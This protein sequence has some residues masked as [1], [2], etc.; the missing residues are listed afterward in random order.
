MSGSTPTNSY[1]GSLGVLPELLYHVSAPTK[2]VQEGIGSTPMLTKMFLGPL[3]WEHSHK[4]GI[5]I[6]AVLPYNQKSYIGSEL[7]MLYNLDI[8]LPLGTLGVLPTVLFL[9]S[10]S[11]PRR[12]IFALWE[13]SWK[14]YFGSMGVLPEHLYLFS[15]SLLNSV[16]SLKCMKSTPTY[17]K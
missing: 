7:D 15:G 16:S 2:I 1:F 4:N 5:A 9:L 12:L 8:L 6:L 14:A 13:Y 17:Q 11:T 3:L 10:G